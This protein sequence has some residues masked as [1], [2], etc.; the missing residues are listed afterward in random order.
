MP[1]RPE[2]ETREG[3]LLGSGSALNLVPRTGKVK[4]G[5]LNPEYE[6]L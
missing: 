2:S 1:P 3:E 5:L 6:T 4:G